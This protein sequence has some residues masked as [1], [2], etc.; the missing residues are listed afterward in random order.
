MSS[1]ICNKHAYYSTHPFNIPQGASGFEHNLHK[2]ISKINFE[3][4]QVG[5]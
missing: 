1:Y 3:M 5:N 2:N 4:I